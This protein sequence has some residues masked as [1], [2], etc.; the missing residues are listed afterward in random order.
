VVGAGIVLLAACDGGSSSPKVASAG[1]AK[2]STTAKKADVTKI[3]TEFAQ[4]ARKHG[5]PNLPDPVI[6][7][8]GHPQFAKGTFDKASPEVQQQVRSACGS[9]LQK[10]P[11][12]Q[13]PSKERI[14]AAVKFAQCMRQHGVTNFPDPDPSTGRFP[15]R[16]GASGINPQDPAFQSAR[17]ACRSL[18][19]PGNG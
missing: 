4:C 9:I 6:N 14:D 19:P 11:N 18:L 8:K 1:D 15:I 12:S 3:A 16:G 17:E 7:D 2:S 5:L 13:K 10:L